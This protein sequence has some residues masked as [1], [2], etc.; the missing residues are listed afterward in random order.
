M[1]KLYFPCLCSQ[2]LEPTIEGEGIFTC[3][4]CFRKYFR[5][6]DSKTKYGK[7]RYKIKVLEED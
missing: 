6:K 5:K 4:K 2:V 7:I 3:P 1:P